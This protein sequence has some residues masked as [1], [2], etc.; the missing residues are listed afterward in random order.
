M[1]TDP[2][3]IIIDQ[4]TP[5]EPTP[6]P[7]FSPAPSLLARHRRLALALG[8]AALG[9]LVFAG[10]HG[11]LVRHKVK[12]ATVAAGTQ[13]QRFVID[14]QPQP[15][16]TP[17]P[18]YVSLKKE[19]IIDG[20]GRRSSVPAFQL[21]FD[22]GPNPKYTPQVLD[23]L[24]EN[25]LHATFFLVGENVARYP[26]LVK[27]I[28]AEGHDIGNHSWSHPK[29]SGM[30]DAKVRDQIK[31]THDAIVSA[32]GRAPTLFR[33]PYGALKPAQKAWI[34][35][36]FGYKTVLWDIDTLDWTKTS[37]AAVAKRIEKGLRP[38]RSNIILSHDIHPFILPALKQLA[39]KLQP[40]APAATTVAM[41][42]GAAVF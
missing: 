1:T 18:K 36:E 3:Y 25:H 2:N 30:S 15:V 9:G 12:P 11:L 33:P 40:G 19:S 34:E 42:E 7:A 6:G 23:W 8:M 13:E 41:G 37:S 4:G 10:G 16:R 39:P 26:G 5:A 17:K 14:P 20:S 28:V 31:R 32:C 22:D 35:K 38:G 24:K 21:T 27:R 29:L